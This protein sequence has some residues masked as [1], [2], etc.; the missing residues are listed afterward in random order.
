MSLGSIVTTRIRCPSL[1]NHVILVPEPEPALAA[2]PNHDLWLSINM[3]YILST[4]TFCPTSCPTSCPYLSSMHH[5]PVYLNG[6]RVPE[7]RDQSGQPKRIICHPFSYFMSFVLHLVLKGVKTSG[8]LFIA[9]HIFPGT[10]SMTL[11]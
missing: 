11:K 9:L 2:R 1:I 3:N 10:I 4:D 8:C 5:V 6:D 7:G